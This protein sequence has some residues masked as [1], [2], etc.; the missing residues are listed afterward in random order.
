L[1]F[2]EGENNLGNEYAQNENK[3]I[4]EEGTINLGLEST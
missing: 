2:K 3:R 1:F 4:I